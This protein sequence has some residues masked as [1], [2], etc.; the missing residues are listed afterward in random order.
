MDFSWTTKQIKLPFL[1][2]RHFNFPEFHGRK[3]ANHLIFVVVSWFV[4]HM[5]CFIDLIVPIAILEGELQFLLKFLIIIFLQN[6]FFFF[7]MKRFSLISIFIRL[8]LNYNCRIEVLPKKPLHP[9]GHFI[10][11]VLF[12]C[13][14]FVFIFFIRQIFLRWFYLTVLIKSQL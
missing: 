3:I 14:F 10:R 9:F 6:I 8:L 7:G 1:R 2:Q 4:N 5:N 13:L 12:I 11:H